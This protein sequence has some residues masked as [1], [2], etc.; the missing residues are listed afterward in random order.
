MPKGDFIRKYWTYKKNGGELD[1]KGYAELY[2]ER[3]ALEQAEK[4]R[5]Q[6]GNNEF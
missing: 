6:G 2:N 4:E 3:K 1:K 5:E